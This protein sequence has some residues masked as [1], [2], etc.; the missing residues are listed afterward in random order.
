MTK[1]VGAD[2]CVRPQRERADTQVCPY[3]ADRAGIT[4]RRPKFTIPISIVLFLAATLVGTYLVRKRILERHMVAAM[5]MNDEKAVRSLLDAWPCPVNARHRNG[6]TALHRA[7]AKGNKPMVTLLIARGAEVNARDD[8][9]TTPLH[10]AAAKGNKAMVT[11]LIARGAE[12]NAT[13]NR[14]MTPLHWATFGGHRDPRAHRD[15]IEALLNAGADPNIRDKDDKTPLHASATAGR[16]E[17][18]RLLLEKGADADVANRVGETPLHRATRFG[19]PEAVALLLR[20]GA[21]V[22][23]RDKQGR[24]PLG[25]ATAAKSDPKGKPLGPKTLDRIIELLRKH[26]ATA[27][28]E[29]RNPKSEARNEKE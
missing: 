24:T 10:W 1:I 21:Q 4:M 16:C 9:A 18:M 2:L 19:G 13:D 12:V 7:A 20:A 14:A 23:P 26:G 8:D 28:A 27:D 11:L 29:T 22:N 25:A 3:N 5:E 17:I 6:S 15:I